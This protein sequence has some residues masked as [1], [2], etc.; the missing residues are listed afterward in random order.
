M[1]GSSGCCSRL[2][3]GACAAGACGVQ[4]RKFGTTMPFKLGKIV[5]FRKFIQ[6]QRWWLNELCWDLCWGLPEQEQQ[7]RARQQ[8]GPTGSCSLLAGRWS[9]RCQGSG[10]RTLACAAAT[11]WAQAPWAPA[12]RPKPSS[13]IFPGVEP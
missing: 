1:G 8:R 3:E 12:C 6:R 10:C 11:L 9:Q 13:V 5:H 7:R 4:T 2:V